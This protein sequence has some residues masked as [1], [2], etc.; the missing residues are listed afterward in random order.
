MTRL[1]A[2]FASLKSHNFRLFFVGQAVSATGTWMQKIGQAWLV[3]EL[4]DSGLL[5][6]VTAAL[7]QLPT[8]FLGPWGGLLADRLDKRR[9]LLITQCTAGLLALLLGIL[10]FTDR[11]SLWMVLVL[12]LLLGAANALDRPARQSFLSEMVDRAQLINAVTLNSVLMNSARV[13]G[14]ALAG[15]LIARVGLA[16]S[17]FVNAAS[18]VAVVAALLLMRTSQLEPALPVG[19][20]RGQLRAGVRYIRQTP[21]LLAPLILTAVAGLFAYE[22]TVTIP[23]L[24]RDAFDGDADTFG[25]MYTAMGLG[26]VTGGLAVA[27]SIRAEFPVMLRTAGVFS[28]LVVAVAVAPNLPAV[29]VALVFVGAASVTLRAVTNALLQLQAEPEMRGRVMALLGVATFG[30]TPLGAPLIGWISERFG[31]RFA[32]GLGG[33]ATGLA[34][35]AVARYIRAAMPRTPASMPRRHG[36]GTPRLWQ[37]LRAMLRK[38]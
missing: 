10:T 23:L 2:T 31:V 22:W 27:G 21:G 9:L 17:F 33:I 34:A 30:M 38:V 3:L 7:Q 15:V 13:V 28:T 18:F 26:A 19:R 24:A 37:N 36:N 20:Q 16:A 6:G 14:P 32:V 4:T 29:L 5:L 1:R 35:L 8:L 12:A 25:M 11:I